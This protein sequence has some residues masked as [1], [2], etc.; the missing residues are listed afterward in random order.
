MKR[1]IPV[2]KLAVV[3]LV[4]VLALFGLPACGGSSTS[5][6]DGSGSAAA[7]NIQLN[8][9]KYFWLTYGVPDGW[10]KYDSEDSGNFYTPSVGGLMYVS[11]TGDITFSDDLD[12]DMKAF[13]EQA[14]ASGQTEIGSLE[15]GSDGDAVTY[16]GDLTRTEDDGVYKGFAK[17]T[18]SGSG[19][20]MMLVCVPEADLENQQATL[21]AIADSMH[22]TSPTAPNQQDSSSDAGS[23]DTTS[24]SPA[25]S[26]T[27]VAT[28]SSATVSQQNAV[29]KAK[30]YVAMTGFSH[31]GLVGQLEYEGFSTKDATYGADNCGADWNA[32]ALEKAKSYVD[33]SG[34]SHD[35]LVEQLEY[36]KF[37]ADQAAYGADNC[38]ADWNAEAAEKAK[39]YMEMQSFSRSGLIDQ[40][41]YEGFTQDQAAYGASS[42]GL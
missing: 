5:D 1:S 8:E 41:I 40:L 26:D 33:M 35:G 31:D 11:M 36:E 10:E 13:V 19:M 22:V 28:S 23:A 18:L 32:E 6:S 4:I 30:S 9:E 17:F 38:G 42:V 37:T 15:R 14:N 24:T 20:Y 25:N 29:A 3:S 12:S 27:G 34:F 16:Q 39:S 21:D 7:S 2:K